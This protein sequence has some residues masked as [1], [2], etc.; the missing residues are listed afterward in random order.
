MSIDYIVSTM[1]NGEIIHDGLVIG[2]VIIVF[3]E[4]YYCTFGAVFSL[5]KK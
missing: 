5:F 1:L 2:L 3:M 4:F